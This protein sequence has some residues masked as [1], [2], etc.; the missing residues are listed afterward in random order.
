MREQRLILTS[1]EDL[2]VLKKAI[3]SF[4]SLQHVQILRVQ[5]RDDSALITYMRQHG[6]AAPLVD[7]Q[8]AP[9]CSHST[10]T[11]GTALLESNVPWCHFS[12]PMLSPQ[13]AMVLARHTPRSFSTLAER[14]TCLELHFDDGNDLDRRML[15]LSE[16]FKTVFTA[17]VNMQAVHVG[18]PTH[19]PLSLPLETLFHHVRWEKLLAFGIQGWRLDADEIIDLALR[20]SRKLKGLRLRDVLLKEG[21]RWRDVLTALRNSMERLDWVSLRRIGYARQ[22]DEQWAG[23]GAEVPDDPPGGESD[24]DSEDEREDGDDG[25]EVPSEAGPSHAPG[26]AQDDWD[27]D[28]HSD[29]HSDSDDEHG[30][31]AHEMDFPPLHSPATPASAPWCNCNNHLDN[32]DDLQDDEGFVSNAK[33]KAW[34]KWVV[35][36]CPEHSQR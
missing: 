20:H 33:R 10:H 16:L 24:S 4:S 30:P 21:S 35:R 17:A 6:D 34:E 9:A 1:K 22:F 31:A 13:S 2:R 18:F 26:T 8:W 36:R 19:R 27:S 32:A 29:S 12:S 25:V 11:I 23:A 28:G 14:L 15:D 5:D 3:A 7:L